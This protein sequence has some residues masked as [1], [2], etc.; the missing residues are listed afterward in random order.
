MR[1]NPE[2]VPIP[3]IFLTAKA[4]RED[5]LKGK[6]MGV[7]E[8]I[9]KPFDPQ[10]LLV[11]VRAR[12]DRSSAIRKAT[13]A[14]FEKLKQQIITSLGHELRTPL[15]YVCG[16]TDLALDDTQSLSPHELQ[17]F[18]TGIKRGSDRLTRL[19]EDL[20]FLIRIDTGQAEDDFDLM[21]R[22]HHDLDVLLGLVVHQQKEKASSHAVILETQIDPGLPP[23]RL[24]EPFFVDALGRLIDNAI[25]FSR[26]KAGRVVL[27][28]HGEPEWVQ[29]QVEDEGVGI[30]ASRMPQL[31]Q[32]FHQIDRERIEQQGIGVGLAI[33]K[34]LVQMHHGE[35][36]VESELGKGSTFTVRLPVTKDTAA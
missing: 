36:L 12:L 35:L 18:L 17:D 26:D 25:K 11:A 14:E 6:G 34:E 16:Y 1:S 13:E 33:A 8:Y 19:V 29:I 31:F 2:W 4:E 28:A 15:T 23:V 20:M 10:E 7:E 3:F 24:C 30:P 27:R 21:V 9:T 32:R 22:V 5:V